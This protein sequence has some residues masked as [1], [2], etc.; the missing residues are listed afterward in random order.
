MGRDSFLLGLS[1]LPTDVCDVQIEAIQYCDTETIRLDVVV[2]RQV[3]VI[4]YIILIG[5]LLALS[6]VVRH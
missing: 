1:H 6:S 3:P 4:G 5:G 2:K